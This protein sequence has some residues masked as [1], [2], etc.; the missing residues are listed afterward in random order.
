MASLR[1]TLEK[2]SIL[3]KKCT[4]SYNVKRRIDG[5][6]SVCKLYDSSDD[7]AGVLEALRYTDDIKGVT[8][9]V[10]VIL[11]ADNQQRVPGL[12]TC[13]ILN[14]LHDGLPVDQIVDSCSSF[15][16][17]ASII[18]SIVWQLEVRGVR[19]MSLTTESIDANKEGHVMLYG[20][21]DALFDVNNS[22][23]CEK[24]YKLVQK[25]AI[26][27]NIAGTPEVASFIEAC[28]TALRMSDIVFHPYLTPFAYIL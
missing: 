25:L 13:I 16:S 26:V 5:Q 19:D 8:S 4:N 21:T 3:D 1:N 11:E 9:L 24:Y 14:A 7:V 23:L 6:R 22:T 12:H 20:T 18:A 28:K 15:Q 2:Y 10:E 17:V 27:V